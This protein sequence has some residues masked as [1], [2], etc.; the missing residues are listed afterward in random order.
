M[1]EME[2]PLVFFTVLAQTSIG[3][4]LFSTL[5]SLTFAEGPDKP[6]FNEQIV[7]MALISVALLAS[8][9]H[10]GHPFGAIRT[11]TGLKHAWLSREILIFG[12]L[13]SALLVS[14]VLRLRG[15]NDRRLQVVTAIL[16]LIALVVQGFTYAPPSEP[17]LANGV[18]LVLFLFTAV[19]LGT[20]FGSWFVSTE[21][22]PIL[23]A[24]LAAV[25]LTGLLINLLLPNI[26]LTGGFI[27]EMTGH[28][29]LDSPL[30]W[31]RLLIG[32]VV[33]L[34]ILIRI[35]RIPVW[36]PLLILSGELIGRIAFFSLA[37]S[38]AQ[39]IGMP[40]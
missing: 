11:L 40:L 13:S 4:V 28:A 38:T 8:L 32:F 30:Y 37:V 5:R 26:W 27:A 6:L 9:A 34:L 14:V 20:A 12:L 21:K 18:P 3:L 35:R 7:A 15:T 16:G 22:Q 19:T 10:L 29:Y 39:H 24:V 1:N 23:T 36:L 33:P 31:G 17:T 25:L 2:L